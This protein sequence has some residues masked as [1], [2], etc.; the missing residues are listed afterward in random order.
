MKVARS[1]AADVT[2]I[3]TTP[4]ALSTQAPPKVGA[5][6]GSRLMTAAAARSTGARPGAT[7]GVAGATPAEAVCP[8]AGLANAATK[9]TATTGTTTLRRC[10]RI[11]HPLPSR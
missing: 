5:F 3:S 10:D 11:T 6:S 1:A 7:A 8:D 4:L 9:Q 2:A